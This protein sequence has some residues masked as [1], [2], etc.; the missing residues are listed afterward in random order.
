MY[1][2]QKHIPASSLAVMPAKARPHAVARRGLEDRPGHEAPVLSAVS[3]SSAVLLTNQPPGPLRCCC[4]QMECLLLRHNCSVLESVENDVRIAAKLGQ[5]LLERHEAYLADAERDRA[6]LLKRID[7]LEMDKKELEAENARKIEENRALLDQ[8]EALNSNVTDS[9]TRLK[10]LEA[11]LQSSQ[12]IIRRLEGAAGRADDM[13]RHLAALEAEQ[14]LL[15]STLVAS[16]SEARSAIQRWKRAERGIA[17]LQDQLERMERETKQE[18]E[19]HMEVMG[20]VERQRAV[21][22]ELS[23][24]AGR[25]KGAAAAKSLQDNNKAGGSGV[26][27][28]FVRDLLQDNASM[29]LGMAELREMLINSNDEIQQL[30]DQLMY[31]QPLTDD[32]PGAA[33]TLRAELEDMT[34]DSPETPERIASPRT[35]RPT[36]H[37]SALS[38]E[39]HIHHH[40][41]VSKKRAE[42]LRPKKKRLGLSP[43]VFTPPAPIATT[44]LSRTVGLNHESASTSSPSRSSSR[45]MSRDSVSTT[46]SGPS[47]R[48]SGFSDRPSDFSPSSVPSSP[49]TYRRSSIFDRVAIP[50]ISL[51][52][53]PATSADPMSPS[54]RPKGC[55]IAT[56]DDSLAYGSSPPTRMSGH[57]LAVIEDD[58]DDSSEDVSDFTSNASIR[59]QATTPMRMPDASLLDIIIPEEGCDMH[60]ETDLLP[61]IK[62]QNGRRTRHRTLSQESIV[63]LKGGLDIHTL[64][65]RPSQLT[66]RPLG[67]YGSSLANTGISSVTARPIISKGR[68]STSRSNTMLLDS[69]YSGLPTPRSR[70]ASSSLAPGT[71]NGAATLTG[72]RRL[73]KLVGW[74]PWNGGGVASSA[75]NSSSTAASA[76]TAEPTGATVSVAASETG[77]QSEISTS[78]HSEAETAVSN[79]DSNSSKKKLDSKAKSSHTSLGKSLQ[80]MLRAPGINQP[81][82]VPGFFEYWTTHQARGVPSNVHPDDVDHEALRDGLENQ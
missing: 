11:T 28:H 14:A 57:G 9:D 47:N 71:T 20:R 12:Q 76:A 62:L 74:R 33:S 80:D 53:S 77:S 48:W 78:G 63:S 5:S 67:T 36:R 45:H 39:L 58:E 79:G 46:F 50:D 3:V 34:P 73:S 43:H 4:G 24:A 30:R 51:P 31:H 65:T 19:R 32:N 66:L 23:T 60:N 13:E 59:S 55:R 38:Q 81:G 6:E 68:P 16:E 72:A 44:Q 29:Q 37:V 26:V 70:V 49:R 21:E 27:S 42:P 56:L 25:L 61:P 75:S 15:Q 64:K 8:L 7:Q 54:W 1:C 2:P 35:P 18:K 17:D 69:L 40:H 10:L 52:T 41:H 22:K 82:P